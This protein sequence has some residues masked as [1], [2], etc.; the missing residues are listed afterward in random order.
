MK[1]MELR[2]PGQSE[3]H[4]RGAFREIPCGRKSGGFFLK[5]SRDKQNRHFTALS[6]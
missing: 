1:D 3:S 5:K 4:C 2:L 6:G